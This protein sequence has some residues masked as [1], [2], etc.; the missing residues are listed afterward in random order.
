MMYSNRFANDKDKRKKKQNKH[1][2]IEQ[3]S[4]EFLLICLLILYV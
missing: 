4:S 2:Q 3:I 1:T